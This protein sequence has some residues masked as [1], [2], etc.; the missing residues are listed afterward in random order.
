MITLFGLLGGSTHNQFDGNEI[1][2]TVSLQIS[3]DGS[4]KLA[5]DYPVWFDENDGARDWPVGSGCSLDDG[6][7][8]IG[9]G[10]VELS[11]NELVEA[12]YFYHFLRDQLQMLNGPSNGFFH[13]GDK[14]NGFGEKFVSP[15]QFKDD[16]R[17]TVTDTVLY[18]DT[19]YHLTDD[20]SYGRDETIFDEIIEPLERNKIK[21]L[22]ARFKENIARYNNG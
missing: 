10:Q 3:N 19:T 21:N 2:N 22:W 6:S 1:D 17:F 9:S 14:V 4:A 5:T 20:E 15:I 8:R 18:G 12:V 13:Q 7:D 16:V 11:P